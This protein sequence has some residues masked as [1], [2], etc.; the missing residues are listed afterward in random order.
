MTFTTEERN[1]IAL[2]RSGDRAETA[3]ELRGA[4]S[5]IDEAD[6]LAAAR[7]AIRKLETMN[8]AEYAA[9]FE[10]EYAA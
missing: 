9:M 1:L 3:A 5:Y 7:S 2:Y 4:L 6:T 8:G 10:V